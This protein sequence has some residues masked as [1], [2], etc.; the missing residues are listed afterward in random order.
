MEEF[1]RDKGVH[2]CLLAKRS[3][4]RCIRSFSHPTMISLRYAAALVT[5]GTIAW[6]FARDSNVL[7]GFSMWNLIIHFVYFQLPSKSRAV[8]YFHS[9]SFT[10]SLLIPLMYLYLLHF[11]PALESDHMETWNI[12]WDEA[13][14]RSFAVH[15]APLVFHTLDMIY[16]RHQLILQYR[17]KPMKFIYVWSMTSFLLLGFIYEFCFPYSEETDRLQGITRESFVLSN[18]LM[19]IPFLLIAYGVLYFIILRPSFVNSPQTRSSNHV[20]DSSKV[21]Q[22]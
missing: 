12:S 22:E 13:V 5:A 14:I 9:L 11:N 4:A 8:A 6:D 7:L 3:I 10:G 20:L 17:T 21:S 15:F 2:F 19:A 18:K 16:N 1:R